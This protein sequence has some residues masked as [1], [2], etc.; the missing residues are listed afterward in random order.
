M[1][2]NSTKIKISITGKTNRFQTLNEMFFLLVFEILIHFKDFMKRI[3]WLGLIVFISES[4]F[5]NCCLILPF[6]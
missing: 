4:S 2:Y 6:F 1:I 5:D 3:E